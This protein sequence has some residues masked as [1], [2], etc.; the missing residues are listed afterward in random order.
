MHL[1]EIHRD[2]FDDELRKLIEP[3]QQEENLQVAVL[4]PPK[5]IVEDLS[6]LS[7]PKQL[8][9]SER[10]IIPSSS[11]LYPSPELLTF[12][13]E[14]IILFR[15][16][17]GCVVDLYVDVLR[18]ELDFRIEEFPL[19]SSELESLGDKR[20]FDHSDLRTK[21]REFQVKLILPEDANLYT[22]IKPE[23]KDTPIG[24]IM[25]CTIPRLTVR[26]NYGIKASRHSQLERAPKT[27]VPV[28]HQADEAVD[29]Q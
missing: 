21:S 1:K 27:T 6:S 17:L 26:L 3:D 12:E 10:W 23:Y 29:P 2:Q 8:D 7:A 19:F 4:E 18:R 14:Y 9:Q 13:K 24:R 16:H 28:A 5:P 11:Y 20:L 22:E 15:Q 25:K